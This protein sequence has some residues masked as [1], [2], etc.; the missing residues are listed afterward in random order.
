M[1]TNR[2]RKPLGF[3]SRPSTRTK[4]WNPNL[5]G[6]SA[7]FLQKEF[8]MAASHPRTLEGFATVILLEQH[9]IAE[10]EHHGYIRDRADPHA[11]ARAREAAGRE[12]FQRTTKEDRTKAVDD[13]M[14]SIGDT[15]P[16]CP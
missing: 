11:L 4:I 12:R 14:R 15:C 3:A 13:V 7:S 1:R 10:C 8:Y 6:D 2:E 5:I 16:E 9:A